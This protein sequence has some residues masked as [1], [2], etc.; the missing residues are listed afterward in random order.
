MLKYGKLA[1]N[2]QKYLSVKSAR[3]KLW[4]E[5]IFENWKI[6]GELPYN[7]DIVYW[8]MC[9][10]KFSLRNWWYFYGVHWSI[11]NIEKVL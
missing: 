2:K 3:E 6:L 10:K 1:T 7:F 5:K 9:V 11:E 4:F 8:V